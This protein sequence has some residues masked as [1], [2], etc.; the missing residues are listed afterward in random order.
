M[1][2]LSFFAAALA[3][4]AVFSSAVAQLV[5]KD[6]D[7]T[8]AAT[9]P[10]TVLLYSAGVSESIS[11]FYKGPGVSTV[12]VAK[13]TGGALDTFTAS[14]IKTS[15]T[16]YT[17]VTVTFAAKDVGADDYTVSIKD[18]AGGAASISGKVVS[19]GFV[20]VDAAG[21][22]VSGDE[23]EGVTVGAS[24][25]TTYDVKAVGINGAAVSVDDTTFTPFAN[26]GS[27]RDWKVQTGF[28]YSV[29]QLQW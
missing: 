26:T 6:A 13:S 4:A 2:R 10:D 22:V 24:G 14:S 15:I 19:A 29:Y 21:K 12:S 8:D 18:N 27:L 7:G 25:A 1:S 16:G 28:L 11:F 20:I 23:A 17:N 5:Y 3:L 9:V